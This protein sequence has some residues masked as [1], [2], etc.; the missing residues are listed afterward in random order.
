VLTV[1]GESLEGLN[2]NEAVAKIRGEKGSEVE[3][4]IQRAGVSDPF[5]VTIV[6]DE[7]PVETVYSSS[8]MV[9]G[10]LTGIIEITNFSE[11]T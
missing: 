6:R 10:K 1:D 3:L 9:D 11:N 5:P 8:E 4:E 2:L 7:I